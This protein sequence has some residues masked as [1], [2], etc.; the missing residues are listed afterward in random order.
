MTRLRGLVWAAFALSAAVELLALPTAGA[1]F[2]WW[3][4]AAAFHAVYGVAG[5]VLIVAVSKAL[6]KFWL[7]RPEDSFEDRSGERDA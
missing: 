3:H 2:P 6:G 1:H 7:Q 5:C 4:R